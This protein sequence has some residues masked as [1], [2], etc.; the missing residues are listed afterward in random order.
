MA[1]A[2]TLGKRP[3]ARGGAAAGLPPAL[4]H[5][6]NRDGLGCTGNCKAS[7]MESS[8]KDPLGLGFHPLQGFGEGH[9]ES[10][11]LT[12]G[13]VCTWLPGAGDGSLT[14]ALACPRSFPLVCSQPEPQRSISRGS[15]SRGL[16]SRKGNT[17]QKLTLL[18][19]TDILSPVKD[20]ISNRYCQGS[21]LERGSRVCVGQPGCSS[22]LAK[23]PGWRGCFE[24]FVA[25]PHAVR[26]AFPTLSPSPSWGRD[27]PGPH[28]EIRSP[29]AVALLEMT[30]SAVR[31]GLGEL[32]P[33]RLA[34]LSTTRS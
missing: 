6:G 26:A 24:G 4:G 34:A 33:Q 15:S 12:G 2:S 3:A 9:I 17:A 27:L 25:A 28:G 16:N 18:A 19:R 11:C 13:T 5:A 10:E 23:G 31:L 32:F 21:G 14:R 22:A 29:H 8:A 7:F 20:S 30:S 1:I